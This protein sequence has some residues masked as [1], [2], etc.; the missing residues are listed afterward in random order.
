MES[1]YSQELRANLLAGILAALM[2]LLLGRMFYMQVF[3]HKSYLEISEENRIRIVPEMA[4]RGRVTDRNGRLLIDNR[5]SYEVAAVPSEITNL[6]S[7]A[8]NLSELLEMP[9]E[10]ISK[11]ISESG[12]RRY[13]P[14]R[15]KRDAPFEVVC[16]IEETSGRYP[17][18]VIQLNQSRNYPSGG[19][20]AHLLGYLSEITGDELEKLRSKGYHS[21]SLVGRKG[22]ERAFDDYLRGADGTTYLEVTAKGQILGPLKERAPI[23]PSAGYDI[24]LTI[25]YDL[26]QLGESLFGDTLTGS[27]VA[28][29][30]NTGAVLA[31]VSQPSFDANL[32]TGPLS[33]EDWNM[34]STDERHPLL[35]RCIQATYPP[36]SVYKLIVAGA[37]LETGTI[38]EHTRFLSCTGGY[39]YGR[40]TFRCHKQSGHGVLTLVDAIAA[41]CDVYF[42]QLGRQLGVTRW[43]EYSRACGFGKKTGLEFAD[44]V[45]GLVPD[46]A[47]YDKRFGEEKWSSAL[48]LNLAI[49]Q[50]EILVTPLQMASFYSALAN[51]GRILRPHVLYS[52]GTG[53]EEIFKEPEEVGG[54]PF[55]ESTMRILRRSCV[56][57][58]NGKLGTAHLAQVKGTTVAGKTGTAQ[59]PHG[60]EHAWFCAYAPADNPVIAI[61]CI[62]ENAG[63]GGSV[64]APLVAKMIDQYL[65]SKGIIQDTIPTSM[66]V[67]EVANA[68]P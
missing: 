18:V 41:S 58:V 26:Q 22:A 65:K 60:N 45:S 14:V 53:R 56:E 51:G 66:I 31:F 28:L 29:D 33:P 24:K 20:A 46:V 42:Y 43:A 44:E 40:R 50:G 34:L 3:Q 35:N 36:G 27:V 61:A 9:Q 1:H 59:N 47:Y 11:K 32:F 17:G 55:S 5:P 25:D 8:G 19:M 67:P 12:F 21:G 13:E 37:G 68:V 52:L 2:L 49:G 62:V 6:D 4:V 16:N 30:P 63:H 23:N 64:A 57:V 10:R 38:T 39:R 54:L 48:I 15:L 7:T